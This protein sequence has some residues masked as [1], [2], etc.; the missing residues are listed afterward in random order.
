MSAEAKN[1]LK[2]DKKLI[3]ISY[4]ASNSEGEIIEN[5]VL[6][7]SEEQLRADLEKK[8]LLVLNIKGKVTVPDENKAFRPFSGTIGMRDL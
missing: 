5:E 1:R 3:K 8:G 2:A 7:E 6:A 4:R